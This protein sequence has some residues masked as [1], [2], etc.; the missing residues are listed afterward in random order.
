MQV[1]YRFR[2]KP[3]KQEA[4]VQWLRD[5][6]DNLRNHTRDGWAYLGTWFVLQN[7]G[8]YDAESRWELDDYSAF[9]SDFGDE[10]AQRLINEFLSDFLDPGTPLV[11]TPLKS[12]DE[13]T[14]LPGS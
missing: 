10:T 9:G 3:E 5:N 7:L 14:T 12:F 4:Y 6:E 11:G 1:V 8:D 13:V 2:I